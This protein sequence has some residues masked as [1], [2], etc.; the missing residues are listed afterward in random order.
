MDDGI[1][2]AHG[3]RRSEIGVI[4]KVGLIDDVG[5]LEDIGLIEDVGRIDEIGVIDVSA[6]FRAMRGPTGVVIGF[7]RQSP[8]SRKRLRTI[9]A[10][11]ARCADDRTLHHADEENRP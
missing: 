9:R 11:R 10:L 3:R 1:D 2:A 5:R 8:S 4:E 6:R 7:S